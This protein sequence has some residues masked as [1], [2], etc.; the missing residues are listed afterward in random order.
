MTGATL[1]FAQAIDILSPDALVV[2][3][4]EADISGGITV[5]GSPIHTADDSGTIDEADWKRVSGLDLSGG[6]GQQVRIEWRFTGSGD[7]TYIGA[8]IDDVTVTPAP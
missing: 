6:V 8:Y 4:I 2:N 5:I 1:S 7:G 3:I